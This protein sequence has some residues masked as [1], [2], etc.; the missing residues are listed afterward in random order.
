MPKTG[1]DARSG[2]WASPDLHDPRFSQSLERGLSLLRCFT[3]ERPMLGIADM[4]DELGMNRSTTHRY[5]ITLV[6]LGYLEQGEGRKYKLGMRG[7]DLGLSAIDGYG[8]PD[9]AIPALLALQQQTVSCAVSLVALNGFD[10]VYLARFT[11]TRRTRAENDLG[12][13][14]GSR[15]PAYATAAGK[16]LLSSL[17]AADLDTMLD[18]AKL[19]KLGP[20]T[21]TSKDKLRK[22][23][24]SIQQ[25][26]LA[27]A[28]EELV[29]G[30][31]AIA[32]P[33]LDE[34]GE[35]IAAI[36]LS[37]DNSRVTLDDLLRDHAQTLDSTATLISALLGYED[38]ENDG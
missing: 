3:P 36:G 13:A 7:T 19:T 27:T 26:G 12:L 29:D 10:V 18:D 38:A 9:P 23:L 8:I 14:P 17:P 21:I 32:L 34:D 28:D 25:S 4:A 37:S 5:A 2:A 16:L 35:V 22:E 24:T 20:N 1:P 15:Q 6:A 33:V 11:P 30:L 31:S